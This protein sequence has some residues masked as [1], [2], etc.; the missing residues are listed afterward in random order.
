MPKRNNLVGEELE[1]W[2]FDQKR[3]TDSGCW[4]WTGTINGGYGK[5]QVRRNRLLAH[6]FSLELHLKHPIPKELEVRHMCHNSICINPLHL[7]EGTHAD[8]MRDMVEANRQSKGEELSK[9]LKGVEHIKARGENNIKSKLTQE[10]VLQ[11]KNDNRATSDIAKQYG[12]SGTQVLRIQK[13]TCWKH[14]NNTVT[15]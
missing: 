1:K 3:V 15:E 6:R 11:I 12:V 14:L 7:Q 4:E 2:F 10:Q 9:R 13:G 8:N 5:L